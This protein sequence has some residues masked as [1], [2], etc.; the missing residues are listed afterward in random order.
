MI[1]YI[2]K[3]VKIKGNDGTCLT[4]SK[5]YLLGKTKDGDWIYACL[6]K[7][8][9]RKIIPMKQKHCIYLK[10]DGV[11]NKEPMKVLRQR[12]KQKHRKRFGE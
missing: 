8:K 9:D 3:P 11:V 1:N 10:R 12:V 2:L 5:V 6:Y 4:C 7:P